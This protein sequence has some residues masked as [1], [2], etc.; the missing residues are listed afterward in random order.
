MAAPKGGNSG[1]YGV[2]GRKPGRPKLPDDVRA[3][4]KL[5]YEEHIRHTIEA[6]RLTL[7]DVAKLDMSKIPLGKRAIIHAY[8]NL[9]FAG[10]RSYEDRLWGRAIEHVELTGNNGGPIEISDYREKLAQK[11]KLNDNS[12]NVPTDVN[13]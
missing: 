6:M 3:A 5:S 13:T 10:I 9:D 11:L 8:Q 7:S 12:R 1:S 4:R 2:G